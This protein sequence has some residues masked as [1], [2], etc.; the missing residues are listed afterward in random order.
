M[1]V[2]QLSPQSPTP[3]WVYFLIAI[4]L[5]VLSLVIVGKWSIVRETWQYYFV[6]NDTPRKRTRWKKLLRHIWWNF[7]KIP[8][9]DTVF[10]RLRER[11]C[12]NRGKAATLLR[13]LI[14]APPNSRFC[15]LLPRMEGHPL[16]RLG[17]SK[18]L[19]HT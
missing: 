14:N 3:L 15:L 18:V 8:T 7:V 6:A 1:N 5:T 13:S 2:E 10:K 19:F 11:G 12:E 16:G 9:P 17:Y 4:P